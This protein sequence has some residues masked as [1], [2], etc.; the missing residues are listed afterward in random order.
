[1]T[2]ITVSGSSNNSNLVIGSTGATISESASASASA[3]AVAVAATPVVGSAIYDGTV[4]SG[5][6][7][8]Q[9]HVMETF[10]C[11]DVSAANA[12]AA[13]FTGFTNTPNLLG[14][15]VQF[16]LYV[17]LSS[18]PVQCQCTRTYDNTN[19]FLYGV[20]P[21]NYASAAWFATMFNSGAYK[22][23]FGNDAS[24]LKVTKVLADIMCPQ[25]DV[26]NIE[27]VYVSSG[28]FGAYPTGASLTQI[29]NVYGYTGGY[30]KIPDV[31][32]SLAG[33]QPGVT[34]I[35]YC[36][37]ITNA[38]AKFVSDSYI[39]FALAGGA[40]GLWRA[41]RFELAVKNN[42]LVCFRE[43]SNNA[44]YVLDTQFFVGA[45]LDGGFAAEFKVTMDNRWQHMVGENDRAATLVVTDQ[46]EA[47]TQLKNMDFFVGEMPAGNDAIGG[48]HVY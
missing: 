44:K 17:D 7:S 25:A 27:S 40:D 16:Q 39:N 38:Q 4:D 23:M 19:A 11:E 2:T 32:P 26:S 33:P 29:L 43:W 5:V 3:A 48:I 10:F 36:T 13:G 14:S 18:S 6:L 30:R 24:G 34:A 8:Q 46:I 21:S 20:D 9:V 41:E 45:I 1:M 37:C 28:L 31:T 47:L 12:V 15:M 35:E 22:P 42:I